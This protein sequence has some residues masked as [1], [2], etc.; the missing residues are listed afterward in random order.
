MPDA[1]FG[2]QEGLVAVPP[3]GPPESLLRGAQP[4]DVGGVEDAHAKVK[5]LRDRRLHLGQ[6]YRTRVVPPQ[7]FHAEDQRSWGG[8]C[9][10]EAIEGTL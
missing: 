7:L 1:E 2:R 8:V 10:E 5:G 4:V 3:E 9:A 6:V